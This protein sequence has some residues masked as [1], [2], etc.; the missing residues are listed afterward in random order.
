MK[1]AP[2]IAAPR[3]IGLIW[4]WMSIIA[5]NC[6]SSAASSGSIGSA[7]IISTGSTTAFLGLGLACRVVVFLVVVDFVAALVVAFDLLVTL[8]CVIFSTYPRRFDV[9]NKL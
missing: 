1:N 5:G 3:A 9:I 6:G 7:S 2:K 8:F 4:M